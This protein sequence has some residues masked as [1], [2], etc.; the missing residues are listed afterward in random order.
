MTAYYG[1]TLNPSGKRPLVFNQ[2]YAYKGS[3]PKFVKPVQLPCAQ[4]VGCRLERSRQWA[5]RCVHEASLYTDNCFL[6]LTY[7]NETLPKDNSLDKSHLQKFMKRLRRRYPETTIRFYAC[8]EYGDTHNRPHYHVCLFNFD[9]EDKKLWKVVNGNRLYTSE[10][11]AAIWT[12]GYNVI[13]NVTF[14]S[15]AYVARYIMKK[16]SGKKAIEDKHYDFISD[17]TGEVHTVIPEFNTMSRRPGIAKDWYDKFKTDLYPSD[18]INVNGQ[19]MQPPKYYDKQFEMD[20]PQQHKIIKAK[21]ELNGKKYAA[22]NTPE[23]LH[24][25]E[26]LKL[27]QTKSLIRTTE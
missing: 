20:E 19:T 25:R 3:D 17:T 14:E 9:F 22:N 21:R 5:I 13:G 10:K 8:G 26:K 24:T 11:L 15:A 16:V 12:H 1:N 6:T 7:N 4:C 2:S 27:A 18:N 23:R